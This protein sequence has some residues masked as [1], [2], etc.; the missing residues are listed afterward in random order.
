MLPSTFNHISSATQTTFGRSVPIVAP[1]VK[2]NSN[3]SDLIRPRIDWLKW[4][5]NHRLRTLASNGCET[6]TA[7]GLKTAPVFRLNCSS[8]IERKSAGWCQPARCHQHS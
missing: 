7:I 5:R 1:H 6:G 2:N 3:F 8:N 4:S